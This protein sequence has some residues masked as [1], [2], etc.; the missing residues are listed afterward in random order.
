MISNMPNQGLIVA[1]DGP[2]GTGKSVLLKTLI[3]TA[4]P[5]SGRIVLGGDEIAG[6]SPDRIARRGMGFVPQDALVGRAAVI[7][8]STD[9]SANW[10]LP[11]TWFTAARFERIGEGF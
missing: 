1:V 2:S 3:G 6:L 11:W 5:A 4:R 7:F 9:G 10:L 8:W